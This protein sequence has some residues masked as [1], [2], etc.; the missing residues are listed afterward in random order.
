MA[1]KIWPQLGRRSIAALLKLQRSRLSNV[2][3]EITV[4]CIIRKL[5]RRFGLGRLANDF[6]RSCGDGE[7]AKAILHLLN[8]CPALDRRRKRQLGAYCME[9]LHR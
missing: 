6:C 9:Y 4:H 3:G 1:Q 8:A 5:A 7:K 2:V